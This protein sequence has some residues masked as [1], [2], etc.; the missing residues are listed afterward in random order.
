[1]TRH[2]VMLSAGLVIATAA[3]AQPSR[4]VTYNP[5]SVIRIDARLR[6][7]TLVVLPEG[8]EILDFV[9]GDKD[10]WVVSGADN[11][12][13]IKPAKAGA[14]TNLNLVTAIGHVYSFLL[15]EGA[16]DPDLKVFV[17]PDTSARP[18]TRA[19]TR[20][21]TAPDVDTLRRETTNARE[22]AERIKRDAED[23]VRTTQRK[24]QESIDAFKA[25]YP[26][27]LHFPYVFKARS[28]P[29][30]VTAIYHDDRFTYIRAEGR[31]LP[32]L[33]EV[34]DHAPNLVS[35][36]VEQGVYVVPKILEHGYLAIGKRR[37]RFDTAVR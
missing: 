20:S 1:M 28:K 30:K 8:E 19:S 35:Y 37:L 36:Q 31:E 33:Y 23:A 10:Y 21:N 24:A 32:A 14:V 4:D 7:T 12:A 3:Q 18:A 2:M 5:R 9:C 27:R 16:A 15:T 29:F 11:L 13:Y 22:E 25:A 34:V 26:V 6:M 17:T